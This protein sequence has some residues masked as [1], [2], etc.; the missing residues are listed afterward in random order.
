[1]RSGGSRT[2]HLTETSSFRARSP[3]TDNEMTLI[4]D[5]IDIPERVHRDDFVLHL[6]EDINR[7]DVVLDRYVVTP[8]LRAH[9]DDALTFIRSSIEGRTSK[10]SYLHGSFGAGKSHF[11]AVL[12]L[13]LQ[14]NAAARGIPGRLEMPQAYL[15]LVDRARQTEDDFRRLETESRVRR[16]ADAV[17]ARAQ[18]ETLR[19]RFPSPRVAG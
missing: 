15:T 8:E 3:R 1:M 18:F 2:V 16:A 6:A 9:F 13:I 5:L 7:P 4:K 19:A 17:N 11:M 12:H 10:A 14:G